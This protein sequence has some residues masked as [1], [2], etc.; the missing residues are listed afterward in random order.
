LTQETDYPWGGRVTI[1]VAAAPTEPL[2]MR[3]RIPG[4]ADD[5][6]ISLDGRPLDEKRGQDGYVE[7][8]RSWKPGTTIQLDLPMEVT[9]LEANPLVEEARNQ[10]AVMRGPVVY[11]LE[12]IDLP[13]DVAMDDVRLPRRPEWTVEHEAGLLGGLT[14]LRCEGRLLSGGKW[15][16]LY[17]KLSATEPRPVALE[18]IPYFAWN[19]RGTTEMTVWLPLD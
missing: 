11:C 7:I 9:M 4:W 3:L 5:F 19:N 18:L 10:V 2:A 1:T 16:S 13:E 8:R 12:S 17:R 14:V 6:T 15:N